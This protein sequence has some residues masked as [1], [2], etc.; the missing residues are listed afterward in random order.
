VTTLDASPWI[1]PA[2]PDLERL[3]WEAVDRLGLPS[4]R[5][6]PTVK[7]AGIVFGNLPVFLCWR[8]FQGVHHLVL[9]Q[10]REIGGLVYG[11]RM[12]PL[13]ER[14][15]GSLD[16]PSLAR[17]LAIHPD[18]P[19]GASVHVVHLAGRGRMVVRTFGTAAPEVVAAVVERLT[20]LSG[21]AANQGPPEAL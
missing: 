9:L 11:A 8:A 7:N 20:G 10:P 19:G 1:P 13:P 17:P 18:F 2:A 12:E 4:L 16:L 21:W 5:D 15:L 6:W 3:A 14:W